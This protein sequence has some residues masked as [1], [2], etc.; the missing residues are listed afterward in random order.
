MEED[1]RLI[2]E[3]KKEYST[4]DGLREYVQAIENLL[5]RY[6]QLEEENE[7]LKLARGNLLRGIERIIKTTPLNMHTETDYSINI[8]NN[9]IPKSKVKEVIDRKCKA[10]R[11]RTSIEKILEC[12]FKR[13]EEELLREE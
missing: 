10:F 9:S 4:M 11:H 3:I 5:T 12:E 1:I 2:E 6:K 8:D 13:L 7:A